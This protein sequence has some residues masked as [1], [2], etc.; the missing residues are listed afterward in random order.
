MKKR[1]NQINQSRSL[2]ISNSIRVF[3]V[4][5]P[6]TFTSTAFTAQQRLLN[7]RENKETETKS[8]FLSAKMAQRGKW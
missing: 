3:I 2:L 1:T 8:H 6:A 4:L 7:L 5:S